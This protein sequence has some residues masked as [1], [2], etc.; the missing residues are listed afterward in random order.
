MVVFHQDCGRTYLNCPAGFTMGGLKKFL[1]L[2]FGLGE[3]FSVEL[4]LMDEALGN[5]Y[6]LIDVVNIYS[7][8]YR[9]AVRRVSALSRV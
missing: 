7:Y 6:T 5:D 1:R 2:K 9:K 8:A 3:N 4:F